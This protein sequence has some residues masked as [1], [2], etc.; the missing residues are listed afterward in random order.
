MASLLNE[1]NQQFAVGMVKRIDPVSERVY[2]DRNGD[3]KVW[4]SRLFVIR[5]KFRKN[6]RWRITDYPFEATGDVV[7]ALNLISPGQEVIVN[8]AIRSFEFQ[9]FNGSGETKYSV[10]LSAWNLITMKETIV[11]KEWWDD[12]NGDLVKKKFEHSK[13]P[14]H[15][16]TIDRHPET[17]KYTHE[18]FSPM[19]DY[20]DKK[21]KEE[22]PF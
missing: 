18:T 6:N 9:D 20:S 5:N 4:R 2:T 12:K 11:R 21:P 10:K 14:T 13:L 22:V 7:D 19:A 8:Y 15:Q 1:R 17:K 3:S 16:N